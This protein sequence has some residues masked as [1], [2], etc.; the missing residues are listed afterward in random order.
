MFLWIYD[1]HLL[2]LN[3][4]DNTKVHRIHQKI[5]INEKCC[6]SRFRA[7]LNFTSIREEYIDILRR[8]HGVVF[9]NFQGEEG[10]GTKSASWNDQQAESASS[11]R[12]QLDDCKRE[13]FELKRKKHKELLDHG[14]VSKKDVDQLRFLS[15]SVGQM[16]NRMNIFLEIHASQRATSTGYVPSAEKTPHEQHLAKVNQALISSLKKL[17]EE[18]AETKR[19]MENTVNTVNVYRKKYDETYSRER[20]LESDCHQLRY[21]IQSL[22]IRLDKANRGRQKLSP[23]VNNTNTAT[24]AATNAAVPAV[25]LSYEYDDH[26]DE[27]YHMR[28]YIAVKNGIAQVQRNLSKKGIILMRRSTKQ[29]QEILEALIQQIDS[30][31]EYYWC[32]KKDS[33][34]STMWHSVF[35]CCLLKEHF[36]LCE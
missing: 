15:D 8:S 17:E 10:Y 24:A 36:L 30:A 1:P 34:L 7:D 27:A 19:D 5:L 23:I 9:L 32:W 35:W 16:A 11:L 6:C 25:P 4:K 2:I 20:E 21:E 18:A 12:L 22:E 3:S 26:Q 13:L 33:Q 28:V 31:I 14:C 29:S